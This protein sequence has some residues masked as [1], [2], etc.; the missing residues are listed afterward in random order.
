MLSNITQQLSKKN[1]VTHW[2]VLTR[3][4]VMILQHKRLDA[5]SFFPYNFESKLKAAK[6]I[7]E[8]P[9]NILGMQVF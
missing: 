7:S 6:N 8:T 5:D 3:T 1:E 9:I 4:K 2:T